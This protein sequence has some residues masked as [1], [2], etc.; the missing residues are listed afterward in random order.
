MRNTDEA[1]TDWPRLAGPSRRAVLKQVGLLGVGMAVSAVPGWPA[2]W[3]QAQEEVIPFTDI[4]P[5]FSTR[6]S[7][8]PEPNPGQNIAR[9]DLRELRSW[10]TPAEQFFAVQHYDVPRLEAAQW[11]LAIAGLAGKGLTL[12]LDDLKRRPRIE[13][14]VVFECSGNSPGVFHGMVGN[15]T[16]AGANLRDLLRDAAPTAETKEV[17][18]WGADRGKEN[19]RE[20]AYEQNFARS[21]SLDD[22]MQVNAIL[23]YE[24]NGKPL[25]VV[26]GFPVR[27][28]VPGY[29]GVCNVKWLQRIE[30]SASR[31]MNRFMSRDYVTLTGRQT[32]S[33]IEWVET[34]VTRMRIK[35]VVARVT[36]VR[37]GAGDRVKIFGAAWADGTPLKS[38]DVQIDDGPWQTA[39]LEPQENPFA[40]TFFTLETGAL[41]SGQHTIVSRATDRAGRGQPPN[42]DLKKTRWENNAIFKRTIRV[43]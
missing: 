41:S 3:F 25:P 8:D 7:A 21:L 39:K 5:D 33:G 6:R 38:V 10:T 37:S 26:H 31:L 17:I 32:E 35:S 29:Y 11:R 18:F 20:N 1:R 15:S 34:S 19:I 27:L 28:L 30:F 40:W 9:Q 42:L 4:P 36:R 2:A 23:A 43:A 22:A 13:R 24:M 16:W 12:T 14:T